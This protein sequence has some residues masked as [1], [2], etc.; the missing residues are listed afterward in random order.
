MIVANSNITV[1]MVIYAVRPRIIIDQFGVGFLLCTP[2]M[3]TMETNKA[4]LETQTDSSK[5]HHLS[6]KRS[7]VE[8]CAG[9]RVE[10]SPLSPL[11]DNAV[12]V[13]VASRLFSFCTAF[14]SVV[15]K[16]FNDSSS[17]SLS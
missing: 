15:S 1:L 9:D 16:D 4:T 13:T 7:K 6:M 14:L 3:A 17:K 8:D 12:A 5:V 10:W 2:S 11:D